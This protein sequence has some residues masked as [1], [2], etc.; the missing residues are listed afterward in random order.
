VQ[1]AP[2]LNRSTGVGIKPRTH[3]LTN[4]LTG[5]PGDWTILR[6][7]SRERLKQLSA[8]RGAE[9]QDGWGRI[10]CVWQQIRRDG[11]L[12]DCELMLRVAAVITGTVNVPGR[13]GERPPARS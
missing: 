3:Q 7:I 11:H 5:Q 2:V 10:F 4:H 8:D 13:F 6:T 1:A 9:N 12:F